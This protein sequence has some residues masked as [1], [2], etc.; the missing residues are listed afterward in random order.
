VL[1]VPYNKPLKNGMVYSGAGK[2][3]EERK[4]SGK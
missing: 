1:Q 3:Q 4:K 2:Y